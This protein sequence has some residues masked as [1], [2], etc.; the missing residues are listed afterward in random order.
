MDSTTTTF[1]E[2]ATAQ[3]LPRK[4]LYTVR[5]VSQVLGI[6]YSTLHDELKAGRLKFHLPPGR[7]YGQ[8]IKPEWV[9]EWIKEG[10]HERSGN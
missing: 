8:L 3:G 7:R 1:M 4:L 10:T 6:P 2:V 9:D 5:E